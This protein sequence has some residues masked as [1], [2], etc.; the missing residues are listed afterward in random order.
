MDL[1]SEKSYALSSSRRGLLSRKATDKRGTANYS[2]L[3]PAGQDA[4]VEKAYNR[5]LE[6]SRLRGLFLPKSSYMKFW[7]LGDSAEMRLYFHANGSPAWF[8]YDY[9]QERK[10]AAK[11]PRNSTP[12]ELSSSI[13]RPKSEEEIRAENRKK[14]VSRAKR[15]ISH[16]IKRNRLSMMWTFTFALKPDEERELGRHKRRGIY[17]YLSGDEQRDRKAVLDAWNLAL[18]SI[19]RY[20]NKNNI[21]FHWVKVLEIHDSER[22]S[23]EKRGTYHI[24]IATDLRIDKRLLQRLWGFGQVWFS[25]FLRRKNYSAYSEEEDVSGSSHHDSSFYMSKYVA[26][27]FAEAKSSGERSFTR[28]QNIHLPQPERNISSIRHKFRT[29]VGAFELQGMCRDVLQRVEES[30]SLWDYFDELNSGKFDIKLTEKDENGDLVEM[31]G[32]V[33]SLAFDA[34]LSLPKGDQYAFLKA[35]VSGHLP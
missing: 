17:R 20:C 16:L 6:E 10:Q 26:K 30:H 7:N 28:S 34:R 21:P 29:P 31:P 9:A 19:K 33:V 11:P 1:A 24:H 8:L 18:T 27:D 12:G 4:G 25:D 35:L 32:Y 3:C 23:E 2:P 5:K 13:A 22:T 14:A 15:N